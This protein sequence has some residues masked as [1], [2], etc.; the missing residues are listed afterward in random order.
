MADIDH[1]KEINDEYG[2]LTGDEIL[3]H[4]AEIL[5][6][7]IRKVDYCF[8]WGG[9]EFLL[10]L[11]ETG[12]EEGLATAEKLRQKFERENLL[13]SGR[14]T[15]SFGVATWRSGWDQAEWIQNTDTALYKA[16]N[17][18]RNRVEG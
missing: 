10:L 2:H 18:G 9:E 14:L 6:S 7:G 1:F 16:K 12:L 11:T 3:I 15:I 4:V 13:P 8:R 5:S 17:L